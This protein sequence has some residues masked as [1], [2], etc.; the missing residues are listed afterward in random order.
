MR[1]SVSN[2]SP[3]QLDH[4]GLDDGAL[5]GGHNPTGGAALPA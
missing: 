5:N 2:H 3:A 4:F 1:S